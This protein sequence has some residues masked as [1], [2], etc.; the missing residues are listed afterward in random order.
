MKPWLWIVLVLVLL[1]G[2]LVGGYVLVTRKKNEKDTGSDRGQGDGGTPEPEFGDSGGGGGYVP[3]SADQLPAD[4]DR[5]KMPDLPR[6]G[7]SQDKRPA[8]PQA[9]N[10]TRANL[11]P[12][13]TAAKQSMG[14]KPISNAADVPSGHGG[15]KVQVFGLTIKPKKK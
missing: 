13:A 10:I 14:S 2:V 7:N 12:L 15:F 1:A 9:G 8:L 5:Q 3:P 6:F 4:T 11:K